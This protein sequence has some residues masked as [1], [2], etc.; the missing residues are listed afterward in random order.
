LYVSVKGTV[1]ISFNI[2]HP[3]LFLVPMNTEAQ[4]FSPF[5]KGKHSKF[6][7]FPSS[8]GCEASVE[9]CHQKEHFKDWPAAGQCL[10]SIALEKPGDAK[11]P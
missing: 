10:A 4:S 3:A 1:V 5:P 2:H 6:E 8:K 7:A 9:I 11:R